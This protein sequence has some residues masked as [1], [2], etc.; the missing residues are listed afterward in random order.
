MDGRLI[1]PASPL[2]PLAD[3]AQHAAFVG[4]FAGLQLGVDQLAIERDLKAA[5]AGG[6]ELQTLD[7]L[8]IFRQDLACQTDSLRLVASNRAVTQLNV[9]GG[10]FRWLC[11]DDSRQWLQKRGRTT[12][13]DYSL[14][15][16]E[17]STPVSNILALF[18]DGQGPVGDDRNLAGGTAVART[19]RNSSYRKHRI[20]D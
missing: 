3:D 19:S 6:E 1:L 13:N 15:I 8:F 16:Q 9:H 4:E 5:A 7:L 12:G 11:S 17:T 10:P 14:P 18:E 2:E 20:G